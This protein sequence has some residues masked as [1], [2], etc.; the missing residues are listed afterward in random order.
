MTD[1]GLSS[2][3]YIASEE[4]AISLAAGAMRRMGFGDA[5]D[6]T[7]AASTGS[8]NRRSE[9]TRVS[10]PPASAA[11]RNAGARAEWVAEG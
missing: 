7:D 2:P 1:D 10:S 6:A 4:S 9:I 3:R 11:R 5:Q 8:S